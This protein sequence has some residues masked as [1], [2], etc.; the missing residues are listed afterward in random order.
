MDVLE[1]SLWFAAPEGYV[2]V[3][4][5]LPQAELLL[6]AMLMSVVFATAEGHV[7]SLVLLQWGLGWVCTV[8]SMTCVTTEG[9]VAVI[10]AF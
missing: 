5:P 3:Y 10:R 6:E 1:R 2:D 7:R 4:D 9:H 8:M